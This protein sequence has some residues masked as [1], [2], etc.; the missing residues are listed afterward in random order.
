[1]AESRKLDLSSARIVSSTAH[2]DIF[3]FRQQLGQ[4]ISD[5]HTIRKKESQGR[6]SSTISVKIRQSPPQLYD[7]HPDV[8][9]LA[10]SIGINHEDIGLDGVKD[11]RPQVASTSTTRHL[12]VPIASMAALRSVRVDRDMLLHQ[13]SLVDERAFGIYSFTRNLDDSHKYEARFFSPGMSGEDPATGSAAGPLSFYLY[14]HGELELM[15][16]VA[17]IQA[18]QGLQVG[19]ECTIN[20]HLAQSDS[21]NASE[22]NVDLV[23]S[24]AHVAQGTI[25]VPDAAIAF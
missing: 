5:V 24:G 13:L 23:G 15:G 11:L 16:G 21:S 14:Q 3:V 6:R 25:L 20:V 2:E 10:A 12:L 7:F 17:S 1:M 18:V 19:R 9:S 8:G 4:G 22:L